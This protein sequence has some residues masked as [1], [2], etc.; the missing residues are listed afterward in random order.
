MGLY[1]GTQ[2]TIII[3][4]YQAIKE[5]GTRD[6]LSGRTINKVG[7]ILLKGRKYGNYLFCNAVDFQMKINQLFRLN[8]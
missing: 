7:H 1:M 8:F 5:L 3:S 6:D 4:D 2:P